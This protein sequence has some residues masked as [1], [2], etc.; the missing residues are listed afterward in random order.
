MGVQSKATKMA[1]EA[2]EETATPIAT[3]AAAKKAEEKAAAN[4]ASGPTL[5]QSAATEL[6]DFSA[7]KLIENFEDAII[8]YNTEI[9]ALRAKEAADNETDKD[10]TK[11]PA[12]KAAKI[13]AVEV[14]AEETAKMA[15]EKTATKN[16]TEVASPKKTAEE[17]LVMIQQQQLMGLPTPASTSD[18]FVRP[19]GLIARNVD[20]IVKV[21]DVVDTGLEITDIVAHQ[22]FKVD[23]QLVVNEALSTPTEEDATSPTPLIRLFSKMPQ[24]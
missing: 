12:K 17:R 18:G 23:R 24:K 4:Q 15:N 1:K 7:K 10:P 19:L 5:Q 11:R 21:F 20:G 22:R 16:S 14:A 3:E 9:I 2:K 13:T 6:S 8:S